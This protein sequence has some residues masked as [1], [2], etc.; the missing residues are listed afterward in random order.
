MHHH[1]HNDLFMY[2][3]TEFEMFDTLMSTEPHTHTH[4]RVQIIHEKTQEM[5]LLIVYEVQVKDRHNVA[6]TMKKKFS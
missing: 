3:H 2:T 1:T 5:Y 4:A 6:L